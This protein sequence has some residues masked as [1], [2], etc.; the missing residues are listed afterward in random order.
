ME[1]FVEANQRCAVRL[2]FLTLAVGVLTSPAVAQEYDLRLREGYD[3]NIFE[4]GAADYRGH[5]TRMEG[6]LDLSSSPG[7]NTSLTFSPGAVF[8]WYPQVSSGNELRGSLAFELRNVSRQERFGKRRKTT[9]SLQADGEYTRALFLRRSVLE[10]LEVGAIDRD[11]PFDELPGRAE[12]QA[13]FAVRVAVSEVLSA[14]AGALGRV[15]DYSQSSNP[16]LP[17]Y[18]KLDSGELGA[19][20]DVGAQLSD[21]WELGGGV[22]WRTRRYSNREARTSEGL[23]VAGVERNLWYTDLETRLAFERDGL[24]NRTYAR[25][26]RRSDRYEGYYSYDQWAV[27]DRFAVPITA[28]LEL[29]LEYSYTERRYERFASAGLPRHDRTHEA[30]AD[31]RFPFASR[32]ELVVGP[33]FERAISND[34]LQDYERFEAFAE[35]RFGR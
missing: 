34:P 24:R 29:R 2:A 8:K 7:E 22:M 25:Y 10:E 21:E 16:S 18:D 28:R 12:G 26:R 15:R 14:E 33:R 20:G 4:I 30:R 9:I 19:F 3:S 32:A 31:V 35:I 6:R 5:Y 13:R 27:E 17:D 1:A 23:E 11:L